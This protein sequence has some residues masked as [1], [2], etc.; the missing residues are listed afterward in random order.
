MT[1]L[2]NVNLDLFTNSSSHKDAAVYKTI[3]HSCFISLTNDV[4]KL[5]RKKLMP[6]KQLLVSVD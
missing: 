5:K 1:P 4:S 3:F 6:A 2:H